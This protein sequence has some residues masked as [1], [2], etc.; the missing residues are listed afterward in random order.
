MKNVTL[1]HRVEY[2]LLML[3]IFI[4]RCL[5]LSLASGFMGWSWRFIAPRLK[6]Q[7]RAMAHLRLAFPEKSDRELHAITLG[8]WDNL[9][10]TFA[11]AILADRIVRRMEELVVQPE[12]YRQVVSEIKR[13]GGVIVSLHSGNW[14]LGGAI[15]SYNG[16]DC[17]VVMQELK[18]PLVHDYMIR[19][20]GQTFSGGVFVKGDRAG[21]RALTSVSGGKAVAIM[22]DLRDVKGV[23]VDFFGRSAPTNTFPARLAHKKGAP[24]VAL[25]IRRKNGIH[26]EVQAEIIPMPHTDDIE[27]DILVATSAVHA[28]FEEWVRQVPE[29]WMWAHRRWG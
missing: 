27:E 1:S 21:M 28:R 16:F 25:Q 10:R 7:K 15:S 26:F 20:R 3:A 12:N 22:G 19:K 24:L 11:E 9:G 4:L 29:Q 18:N 8:M 6:R 23:P 5:P 14:E 17:A 2:W 13:S